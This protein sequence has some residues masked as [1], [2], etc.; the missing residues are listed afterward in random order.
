MILLQ[1][2]APDTSEHITLPLKLKDLSMDK[3]E[4]FSEFLAAIKITDEQGKL[5]EKST[6]L[7]SDSELWFDY[8]A[9]R[10]T[11]SKFKDAVEKVN[12][13]MVI[14]NPDKCRTLM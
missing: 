2:T 12:D 3:I 8:R 5:I 9:L 1:H 4:S 14:K 13:N 6:K 11:A 10:I 7:Q